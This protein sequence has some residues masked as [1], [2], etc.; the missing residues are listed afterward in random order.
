[1]QIRES[2]LDPLSE[3]WV[4]LVVGGDE[5]ADYGSPF[6]LIFRVTEHQLRSVN[7][8]HSLEFLGNK[9]LRILLGQKFLLKARRYWL[10]S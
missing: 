9:S 1:M 7:L 4:V 5:G 3:R 10:F 8:E 2:G 6:L